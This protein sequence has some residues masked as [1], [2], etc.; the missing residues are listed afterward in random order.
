ME[1]RKMLGLDLTSPVPHLMRAFEKAGGIILSLPELKGRDAFAVWAE[2]HPVVG[3]GP[4]ENGDRLRFSMAH[5]IGHLILHNAPAS[6]AQ[7]EKEAHR[8]A[9]ELLMPR[10]AMMEDL[11]GVVTPNRLGELKGKWG[12]SMAAL[13]YRAKELKLVSK[14]NHDRL[15]FE[16]APFRKEEPACFKIPVEQPRGLRQ[17]AELLYG[18]TLVMTDLEQTLA[19]AGAF[20]GDVLGRYASE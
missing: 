11:T 13:L 20:I 18:P 19:L 10:E 6:M 4:S 14:R 16:L 8:F 1:T 12:I 5:E 7:A 9:E 15:I 2:N 3:I 17:M